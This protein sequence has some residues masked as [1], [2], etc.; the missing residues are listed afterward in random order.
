MA[1]R[2]Q[3]NRRGLRRSR[4][5]TELFEAAQANAVRFAESAIDGS[6]FGDAHLGAANQRRNIGGIS[7]S[8]ANEAFRPRR[9]IHRGSEDPTTCHRVRKIWHQLA[10]YSSAMKT[11]GQ[12]Y[13][14]AVCHIPRAVKEPDLAQANGKAKPCGKLTQRLESRL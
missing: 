12:S 3:R 13:Q 8:I 1:I 6:C 10:A 9:L 7:I 11:V 14:S 5:R 4:E 2:L